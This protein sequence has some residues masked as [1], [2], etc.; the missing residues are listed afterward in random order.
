MNEFHQ[1]LDADADERITPQDVGP[2][3]EDIDYNFDNVI[4]REELSY[5]LDEILQALCYESAVID[6]AGWK[7]HVTPD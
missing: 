4:S 2:A 5:K 1:F 7:K 6:R 3:F